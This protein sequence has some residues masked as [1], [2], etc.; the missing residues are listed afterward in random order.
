M[1]C[2]WTTPSLSCRS[3][4]GVAGARLFA[5]PAQS[6]FSGVQHSLDLIDEAQ[7]HGFDVLLDAAAFVPSNPLSLRAHAPEFVVLSFYKLFGYPTGVGALVV[8]N[9]ALRRL[10]APLVRRRNRGFRVRAE[11]DVS[12]QG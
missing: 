11:R 7:R 2:A 9:D 5:F 8:R 3:A 12:A 6:N 4:G 1:T 10:A